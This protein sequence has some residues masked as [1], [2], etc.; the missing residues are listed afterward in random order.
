MNFTNNWIKA[1]V[2]VLNAGETIWNIY[3]ML[4]GPWLI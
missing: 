2:K 4:N 3:V 1:A